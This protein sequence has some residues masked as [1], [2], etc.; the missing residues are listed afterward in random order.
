[1]RAGVRDSVE[2]R[3]QPAGYSYLQRTGASVFDNI[4]AND[5]ALAGKV[6]H[7]FYEAE[8]IYLGRLKEAVSPL[9][10]IETMLRLPA[11]ALQ[12]VGVPAGSLIGKIANLIGWVAGILGLLVSL[13]D[14]Q[15]L[16]R[17]LSA[18]LRSLVP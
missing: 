2:H 11:L 7:R 15:D 3:M 9:Y 18:A 4:A 6:V 12:Y 14:F 5:A 1:M 17:G 8:G 10:W 16:Q 13:P